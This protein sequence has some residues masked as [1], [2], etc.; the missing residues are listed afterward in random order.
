MKDH[1][2]VL[3]CVHVVD[4]KAKPI[5]KPMVDSDELTYACSNCIHEYS[6]NNNVAN[7]CVVCK[8]CMFGVCKN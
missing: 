2:T 1:N 7:L 4:K 5:I 6:E 3:T 8:D